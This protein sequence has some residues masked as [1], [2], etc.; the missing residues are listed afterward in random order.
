MTPAPTRPLGP[1]LLLLCGLLLAWAPA[2]FALVAS[3][4]VDSLAFRGPAVTLLLAFWLLA[5]AT[6]IAAGLAL[7]ARRPAAV[8]LARLALWVSLA[9][10][11]AIYL[12]PWFPNNRLPGTTPIYV[13]GSLAYHLG[14]LTY[15]YRSSRVRSL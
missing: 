10:S 11:L 12:T 3:T 15:L 2:D 9:S 6:G 4:L 14:W 1:W 5:V 13:G 7:L 8:P